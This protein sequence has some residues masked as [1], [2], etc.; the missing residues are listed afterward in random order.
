DKTVKLWDVSTGDH[1]LVTLR[2]ATNRM[3]SLVT[4]PRHPGG[5]ASFA[6]SPDG[7]RLA[8]AAWADSTVNIWLLEELF[9]LPDSLTERIKTLV[10]QSLGT[11]LE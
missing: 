8:T 7:T 11:S 2:G 3:C 9:K 6:F 5:V 4:L 1:S 10:A